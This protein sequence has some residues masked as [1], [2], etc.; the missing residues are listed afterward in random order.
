[1]GAVIV[2]GHSVRDAEIKYGLAVTGTVHPERM[3][4]NAGAKPGH[5]LVLTKP[6]GSGILTSAAKLGKIEESDLVEAIAVMTRLNRAA[7]AALVEHGASAATDITGFGLLGHAHELAAASGVSLR[8][9]AGK[10]PLMERTIEL[11]GKKCLTRAYR[12]TLDQLGDALR[13]EGIEDTLLFTLADAQT[14]GGLLVALPPD[15]ADAYAAALRDADGADAHVVGEVADRS[16][17]LI[18]LAR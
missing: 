11:A 16:D 17:R 12:A 9:E 18:M 4:T 10:V 13:V 14:S 5:V 7:G 8:I 3:V 2:G 6:I 1:A 15:R